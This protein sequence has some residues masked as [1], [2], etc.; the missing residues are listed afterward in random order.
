M[1]VDECLF[2]LGYILRRYPAN[3]WS[4]VI[5][6]YWRG[7]YSYSKLLF[8]PPPPPKKKVLKKT[9]KQTN[10]SK[11][12][13]KWRFLCKKMFRCS[14]SQVYALLPPVNLPT[15]GYLGMASNQELLS[16][17]VRKMTLKQSLL[18]LWFIFSNSTIAIELPFRNLE[19]CFL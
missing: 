14:P 16:Q 8:T 6:K 3:Y 7:S 19:Q 13:N 11:L 12:A 18:L 2:S 15:W 1:F 5:N 10:I 9:N 17:K 4:S